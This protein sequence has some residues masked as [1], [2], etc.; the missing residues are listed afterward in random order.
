MSMQ[1]FLHQDT[2]IELEN[3]NFAYRDTAILKN[4]NCTIQKGEFLGV[5]GPNGAGKTTLLKLICGLLTPQQGNIRIQ[6]IPFSKI[7]H[8][9]RA[10]IISYLPQNIHPFDYTKIAH[11]VLLARIPYINKSFFEKKEDIE[12][13]Q[14]AMKTAGISHLSDRYIHELSG[15]EKQMVYIAKLI[16]Q[17]TE[18]IVLDEP[19]TFLDI[20]HVITIMNIIKKI[21][22]DAHTTVI[23]SMHDLNLAA[24]YCTKILL[25][26]KGIVASS[27]SPKEVFTYEKIKDA[28]DTE[29]Y[30]DTNDLTGEPIV[31]P[32]SPHSSSL[33]K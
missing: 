5:I 31:L 1:E 27:G 8:N 6:G 14:H 9:E 17:Q 16:A 33:K 22:I 2:I 28:F 19:T 32:M 12:A 30:I 10:K 3:I 11:I 7:E 20:K 26:K 18:I 15:G 4:I 25:L 13:V 29:F 24:M 23:A 21:N